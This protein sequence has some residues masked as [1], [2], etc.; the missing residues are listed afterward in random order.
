MSGV[1]INDCPQTQCRDDWYFMVIIKTWVETNNVFSRH[2]HCSLKTSEVNLA[3]IWFLQKV[4]WWWWH[5]NYRVSSRSRPWDMRWSWV[6]Y[7]LDSTWTWLGQGL[8][9]SLTI[10]PWLFTQE[11][12]FHPHYNITIALHTISNN[13]YSY[14]LMGDK[15]LLS[16]KADSW[17]AIASKNIMRTFY[18]I[19]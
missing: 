4:S 7:D 19:L 1:Q 5:C 13:I 9:P 2:F 8:D 18:H 3:S 6:W 14:Q 11:S 12:P 17:D 10:S 15:W 16:D